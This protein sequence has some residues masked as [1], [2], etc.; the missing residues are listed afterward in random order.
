MLIGWNLKVLRTILFPAKLL[1]VA[2]HESCHAITAT[3]TGGKVESIILDPNQGGST[4]MIG[5]WAFASLPAG[6]E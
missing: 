1:T 5:G 4:R 2:F 6:C 3:L